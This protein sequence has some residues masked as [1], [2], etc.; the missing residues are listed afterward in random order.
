MLEAQKWTRVRV[1]WC[2]RPRNG[3]GYEIFGVGGS[4]MDKGTS[5]LV[6]E[7]QKWTGVQGFWCWRPRN[8]LGYEVFGAKGLEMD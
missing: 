8:G 2:W 7:A 6:L 3:L 4:E 1:F 5:L